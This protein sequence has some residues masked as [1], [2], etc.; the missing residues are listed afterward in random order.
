MKK[1]HIFI[2]I[3]FII[4]CFTAGI[5]TANNGSD[6][7]IDIDSTTTHSSK[8]EK[9][10][11]F[12]KSTLTEQ[13]KTMADISHCD[14]DLEVENSNILSATVYITCNAPI[15]DDTKNQIETYI[16]EVTNLPQN[17][18]NIKYN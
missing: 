7:S 16:S 15:D 8:D 1:K 4:A 17:D 2:I 12:I 14:V 9:Y 11:A 3:I 18:I 5:Y 10:A 13:L 6:V